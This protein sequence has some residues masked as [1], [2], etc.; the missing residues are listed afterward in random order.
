MTGPLS[1][2]IDVDSTPVLPPPVEGVRW[3]R[4]TE[5]DFPA[6]AELHGAIAAA[7]H[8]EWAETQEEIEAEYR[9]SW[10]DFDADTVVGERD[11]LMVAFGLQI[12][13]PDP[14]TVVRSIA[15]GGVR[16]S[17][18]GE[19]IGRA[20]LEWHRHRGR[21]QLAASEYELPG[22]HMLYVEEANASGV[23]LMQ[24]AGLPLVRWFTNMVRDL[25]DPIP[26]LALAAPLELATPTMDDLDALRDARNDAFRDHWGSQPTT[27]EAWE[28]FLTQSTIRLDLS[29]IAREGSR[30]VGMVLTLVNPDD[31]ELQGFE[32]GYIP[33]VGVVRDWRR[34]GVAPALLAEVLRRHR[35]AGYAKVALD[36][37]S[38]NPSGALGLYTRMG[39]TPMTRSLA[40]VEEF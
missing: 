1:S 30:V 26:E 35:E 11:G 4:A 14:D 21:Q 18:R 25:G 38:E 40:F 5:S 6:L 31:F 13:P 34:R 24:H 27:P 2:R 12:A 23:R 15:A 29:A 33:N 19:G 9:H 20:L 36:V 7:D 17:H 28:S 10:I 8:P 3:R 39:F 37:D 16:P 32:G 22:W